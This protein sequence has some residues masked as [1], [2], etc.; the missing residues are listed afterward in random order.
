MRSMHHSIYKWPIKRS[1]RITTAPLIS[2]DF[3]LHEVDAS[4]IYIMTLN[5]GLKWLLFVSSPLLMGYDTQD[6]YEMVSKSKSQFSHTPRTQLGIFSNIK[7]KIL[8]LI[9][10]SHKSP[11]TML[12]IEY[13]VFIILRGTKLRPLF[14]KHM[15]RLVRATYHLNTLSS[16]IKISDQIRHIHLFHWNF[17]TQ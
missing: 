16:P 14:C 5:M 12:T 8:M 7:E 9:K 2:E 1:I 4:L 13:R 3:Q 10:P 11:P 17:A 15:S 6:S